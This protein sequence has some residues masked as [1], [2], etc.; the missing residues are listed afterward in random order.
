MRIGR[1]RTSFGDPGGHSDRGPKT[2]SLADSVE[3]NGTTATIL[4]SGWVCKSH[5]AGLAGLFASEAVARF[6]L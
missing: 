1:L 3:Y 5:D 6:P 4:I 2:S